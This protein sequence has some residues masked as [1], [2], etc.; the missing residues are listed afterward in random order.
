MFKFKDLSAAETAED[1]FKPE[2]HYLPPDQFLAKRR[3][4][5]RPFVF[6][7]RFTEDYN[8]GHLPGSYSLPVEHFENSVY[9]M[10]FQGDI[11]LYGENRSEV[12]QAASLLYENGF[13]SFF[14]TD[15]YADLT[16]TL[17]QSETEI[18]LH[19][20]PQEQKIATIEKVLD[21]KIRPALASDGGG[22]TV[23]SIEENRVFVEYHGACGS[24]PSSTSGTLKFIESQLTINLNH[25]M[26][27]IPS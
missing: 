21:E 4:S 8:Q 1:V 5:M 17:E 14:Y 13:D 3:Q 19:K 23:L 20:L 24:C 22:L 15:S 12:E 6:D 2:E 25:D 26:E 11:L 16:H 10:P 18:L 27:V 9:Q 7:L